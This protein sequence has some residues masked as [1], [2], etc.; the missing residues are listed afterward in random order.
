MR[1]LG[2]KTMNPLFLAL[3]PLMLVA[4]ISL[5]FM[6]I[7]QLSF[8]ATTNAILDKNFKTCYTTVMSVEV[9]SNP[10]LKG[11]LLPAADKVLPSF[12]AEVIQNMTQPIHLKPDFPGENMTSIEGTISQ[13]AQCMV[14]LHS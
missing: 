10:M 7:G 13:I 2:I 14:R 3:I 6:G 8:A 11:A 4:T 1:N 12:K 9:Q 5:V